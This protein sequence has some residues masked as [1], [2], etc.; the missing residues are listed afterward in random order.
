VPEGAEDEISNAGNR[1][2]IPFLVGAPLTAV[3][4]R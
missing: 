3:S 4:H 1:G 2:E